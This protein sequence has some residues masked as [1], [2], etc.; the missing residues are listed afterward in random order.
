MLTVIS[1]LGALSSLALGQLPPKPE[2]VTTIKSKFHENVTI[3]FKEV[4]GVPARS[5]PRTLVAFF[6]VSHSLTPEPGS[7]ES[8][9]RLPE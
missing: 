6:L 1:L 5:N 4:R 7:P 8:V 2:G 3:S 9:R